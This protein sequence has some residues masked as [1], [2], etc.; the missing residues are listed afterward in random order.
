VDFGFGHKA[1]IEHDSDLGALR[2]AALSGFAGPVVESSAAGPA[3]GEIFPQPTLLLDS[4]EEVSMGKP[5][6]HWE[7]WSAEHKKLSEFYQKL[8][9]WQIDF[10][11]FPN[12]G[13]TNTGEGGIGG[14]FMQ[15][16]RGRFRRTR[17]PS[18]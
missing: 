16:S 11:A 4:D 10:N 8:F 6:V 3:S 5:V 13:L 2:S 9:D 12:Y 7:I 18:M 17:S 14:G 1:W 15:R